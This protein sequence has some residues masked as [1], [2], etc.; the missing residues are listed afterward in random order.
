MKK[1]KYY[2]SRKHMK[3][4]ITVQAAVIENLRKQIEDLKRTIKIPEDNPF[5]NKE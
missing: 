1:I 3:S 2:G 4:V 5:R